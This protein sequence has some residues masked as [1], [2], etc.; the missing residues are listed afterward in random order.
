MR[1]KYEVMRKNSSVVRYPS[2]PDPMCGIRRN[3]EKFSVVLLEDTHSGKNCWGQLFYGVK[4]KPLDYYRLGSREPTTF[5]TLDALG[6]FI[7]EHGI[8]RMLITDS[9]SILGAG[10]EWK[11]ILGQ[12]FPPSQVSEPDN[13]NQ[14]MVERSIQNLKARCSKNRKAC[15]AGVI[16]HHCDMMEYF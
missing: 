13:H 11:H 9:D 7:A 14:N 16:T 8:P 6:K 12:I 15:G 5:S 10:K 4:Y 2:L 3:K 1:H